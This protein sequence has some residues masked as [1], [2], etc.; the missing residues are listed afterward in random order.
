MGIQLVE[1]CQGGGR[2]SEDGPVVDG[3][4]TTGSWYRLYDNPVT[5]KYNHGMQYQ[6]DV[7]V[8]VS[9]DFLATNVGPLPQRD[10]FSVWP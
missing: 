6:N 9:E 4:P 1:V 8:W 2:G 5:E 3:K 10:G 7:G